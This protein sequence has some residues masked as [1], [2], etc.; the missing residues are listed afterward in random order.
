MTTL[1][2]RLALLSS[3][4]AGIGLNPAFAAWSDPSSRVARMSDYRGDIGY[5]PAGENRWVAMQRNRPLTRGDRLWAARGARAELQIGSA[6]VRLGAETGMTILELDDRIAQF[7]LTQG[8]L[9]IG[10]RRLLRGQSI[11]IATPTLAFVIDRAG[12]YRID[13][14]V[15]G[16]S[17]QTTI[18][19]WAGG[20]RALGENGNFPLRAGDVVRFHSDDIRDY[21]MYALP[22]PD[23]FDRYSNA[24]DLRLE[25][26]PALRHVSDDIVG[27]TDLDDYG[28]WRNERNYGH[29]WYPTQVRANWAPYRDGHWVWQEPWG[30]TWVDDAP[31][32]FAPSHYGRWVQVSGRWGWLPGPRAS[33]SVYA[34]PLVAFV[35]GDNWSLSVNVGSRPRIGWFPLGPREA[36]LPSYRASREYFTQVNTSNTVI[37]NTVVNN[38]Y[39]NY[40]NGDINVAQVNY[41]NRGLAGAITAVPTEAFGNA[42]QVAQVAIAVDSQAIASGEILSLAPI[43]PSAASVIGI[44]QATR[45]KPEEAVF[46]RTVYAVHQ[47]PPM[48]LP[49]A[50]RQAQLQ[51]EPG[52]APA[53]WSG[54]D[55][56]LQNVR[57]LD[58]QARASDARAAGSVRDDA[59]VESAAGEVARLPVLDDRQPLASDLM[60]AYPQQNAAIDLAREAQAVESAAAAKEREAQ[61]QRQRDVDQ[62]QQAQI[63]GERAAT[64]RELQQ[65]RQ[66]DANI[67]Q[68]AQFGTDRQAQLERQREADAA[69]QAQIE[70][71]RARESEAQLQGQR[72]QERA[73]QAQA[74]QS[75][76]DERQAQS[77]RERDADAAQQAQ[78]ELQRARESE[79]Q[80]QGQRDQERAQQAQV[81]QAARDSEAQRQRDGDLA[82]QALADQ[83][84]ATQRDA[85]QSQQA[86]VLADEAAA[87]ERKDPRLQADESDQSAEKDD[88]DDDKP[89]QRKK[90]DQRP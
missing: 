16:A 22:Q 28:S 50:E 49:F 4:L 62:A 26:S 25:R 58:E 12:R 77:L 78:I 72:D 37:N 53:A 75:A 30:W 89:Q 74:E 63:E 17:A 15:D 60:P 43:A 2:V 79:A 8:T 46:D 39:N 9:N 81:E 29:V 21:R 31:W 65:Q 36:Y 45:G 84:A 66:R 59:V 47:P 61:L 70:S 76:A 23:A 41:A 42:R 57:L 90:K 19:V 5:S 11:E 82:Q 6:A 56:A 10:V 14:D 35:G 27:Y 48:A 24:R 7:E 73:Q 32:G 20:G 88:R 52:R 13:V 86:Q 44:A 87:R 67:D 38:I 18:V 33:R 69:Q 1:I 3:F 40:A 34:P 55:Q 54:A 83:A 68:P 80:L 51:E 71:E 85:E 64:E